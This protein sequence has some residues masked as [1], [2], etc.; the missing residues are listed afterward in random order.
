MLKIGAG[1]GLMSISVIIADCVML[2]MTSPK[3]RQY[4]RSM[5]HLDLKSKTNIN[6]IE[7]DNISLTANNL[8]P[9]IKS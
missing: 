5:K 4:F 7:L 6:K 2:N 1:L 3:K 8:P 9:L